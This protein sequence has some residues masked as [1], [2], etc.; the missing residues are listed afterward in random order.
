MD[1]LEALRRRLYGPDASAEDRARYALLTHADEPEAAPAPTVRRR[2]RAPGL[3]LTAGVL[4]VLVASIGIVRSIAAPTKAV[5]ELPPAP[6][7]S[8]ILPTQ[9]V[10]V[11]VNGTDTTGLRVEGNGTAEV[12]L[13][14]ADASFEGGAF[15]V[16]LT[17]SDERPIGWKAITIETRQDWSNFRRSIAASPARDRLGAT[18][19]DE[20]R[21][22]ST[23]PRWIDVQ[24]PTDAVWTLT[25]AFDDGRTVQLH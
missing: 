16:L 11:S 19:A 1:Q 6:T 7:A 9:R 5:A 17:S 12:V 13:G 3:V 14:V 10:A 23:P 8:A 24:A 21:Y 22:S 18:R 4:V 15:T 20:A 2:R 25:V